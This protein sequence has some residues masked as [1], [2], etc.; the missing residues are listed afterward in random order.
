M[1]L[2]AVHRESWEPGSE[3]YGNGEHRQCA[4]QP[5][6]GREINPCGAKGRSMT[7]KIKTRTIF[8]GHVFKYEYTVCMN[9]CIIFFIIFM[10][11]ISKMYIISL[12][13]YY[14]FLHFVIMF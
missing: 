12:F 6:R 13:I 14:Y 7:I 1:P 3:R 9:M 4:M 5:A 10:S 2:G 8:H 11:F